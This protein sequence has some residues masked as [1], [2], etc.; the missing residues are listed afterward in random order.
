MDVDIAS[1]T[2]RKA[3]GW[4]RGRRAQ[5]TLK[6]TQRTTCGRSNNTRTTS[7]PGRATSRHSIRRSRLTREGAGPTGRSVKESR[8]PH[9]PPV[10]PGSTLASVTMSAAATQLFTI[11]CLN[12]A[13]GPVRYGTHYCHVL[14]HP[15]LPT[16]LDSKVP[17]IATF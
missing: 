5:L 13:P 4:C 14:I 16:V 12:R 17:L 8:A 9:R 3:I 10:P 6:R 2:S 7:R 1:G 15:F 11:Y